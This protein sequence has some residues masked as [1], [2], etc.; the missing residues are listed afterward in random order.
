[1]IAKPF[2]IVLISGMCILAAGSA[3][4]QA[5]ASPKAAAS[6]Q[7]TANPLPMAKEIGIVPKAYHVVPVTV[8]S[9]LSPDEATVR[10]TRDGKGGE[11]GG[12]R[13]AF[14]FLNPLG[15]PNAK[16]ISSFGVYDESPCGKGQ[17]HP[18]ID[19]SA[20]QGSEVRAA[21]AGKVVRTGYTAGYGIHL[22][23]DHGSFITLY[24]HL[25]PKPLVMKGDVVEAGQVIGAV[26]DT[27]K[28]VG[29]VLHYEIQLSASTFGKLYAVDPGVFLALGARAGAKGSAAT[30]FYGFLKLTPAFKRDGN[31][32]LLRFDLNGTNISLRAGKS[33]LPLLHP[34]GKNKAD[35]TEGFGERKSPFNGKTEF[36]T[37]IDIVTPYGSPVMS[38]ADG[39]VA[40]VGSETGY[41]SFIIIRHGDLATLFSHLDGKPLVKAGETVK[42]G[43]RIG[44]TGNTGRSTGPHLHYEIRYAPDRGS[45]FREDVK[46][47]FD[48]NDFL[49]TAL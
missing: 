27:G 26:G 10:W 46:Y 37:G 6:P 5:T 34:L 3:W 36:H 32:I 9:M 47:L 31:D 28:C 1:M 38:P 20:K 49:R 21:A 30:L 13:T 45:S 24:A 44:S 7:A 43:Q 39:V 40:K 17:F 18:G 12:L 15:D 25:A 19:F 11:E 48:P 35:V 41:G 23:I 22:A 33:A 42:A 8:E 14:P 29:P 2:F 16:I 4:P